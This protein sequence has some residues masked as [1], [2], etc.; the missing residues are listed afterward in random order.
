MLAFLPRDPLGLLVLTTRYVGVYEPLQRFLSFMSVVVSALVSPTD[1]LFPPLFL[2]PHDGVLTDGAGLRAVPFS[3]GDGA[4][5][6]FCADG[7]V[8][9]PLVVASWCF[10]SWVRGSFS[11]S[12]SSSHGAYDFATCAGL[13]AVQF[14]FVGGALGVFG[15]GGAVLFPLAVASCCLLSWVRGLFPSWVRGLFSASLTG[16]DAGGLA[17]AS[18]TDLP[19]TGAG[20]GADCDGDIDGAGAG[21]GAGAAGAGADTGAGADAGAGDGASVRAGAAG[22]G[23]GARGGDRGL[24]PCLALAIVLELLQLVFVLVR[25]LAQL[26]SS[27]VAAAVAAGDGDGDGAGAGA[28]AGGT[29]TGPGA[30]AGARASAAS[31]SVSTPASLAVSIATADEGQQIR[32]RTRRFSPI[33]PVTSP[34]SIPVLRP[35]APS[36]AVSVA[37]AVATPLAP[38]GP[39]GQVHASALS[40][41]VVIPVSSRVS[42]PFMRAYLRGRPPS[43]P[44]RRSVRSFQVRGYGAL[45]R[46]C[47]ASAAVTSPTAVRGGAQ[48]RASAVSGPVSSPISPSVAPGADAP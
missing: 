10:L 37:S 21:D 34:V 26:S 15:P 2:P 47:R 6:V 29:G 9:F 5:A 11:A 36:V 18:A 8:L 16:S 41:P 20:T 46:V 27:A 17:R 25:C 7:A 31:G 33:F 14:S 42:S 1:S 23:A 12:L 22:A 35:I 13:W 48:A 4:F 28:G 40:G 38:V 32:Q 3:C 24:L 44:V 30:G 43:F 19:G 45:R 39:V